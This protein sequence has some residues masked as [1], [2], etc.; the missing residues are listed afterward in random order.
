MKKLAI[1]GTV[2]I[3]ETEFLSILSEKKLNIE[4][5]VVLSC[6]EK[7]IGKEISY[8]FY[9]RLI[10][11]NLHEYNF[12]G[13]DIAVFI[14]NSGTS[15]IYAKKATENGCFVIDSSSYWR[16]NKN[17]PLIIPEINKNKINISKNKNI[18]AVPSASA[19]QLSMILKPLTVLSEISRVVVSTYQAVS[20]S[21]QDA[22][23]ELFE[24]TKKVYENDFMKP[25][26]F[27]KQIPFNLIPQIGNLSKNN[28]YEEENFIINETNKI[29]DTDIKISATC[30]RVP[31]FAC[32]SQSINIEFKDNIEIDNVEE[33]LSDA[34]GI[35][36]LDKPSDY[37]FAT[38]RECAGQDEI[39]ISRIRKDLSVKNGINLWS[40]MDNVRRGK[41]INLINTLE[42]VNDNF[43]N[44]K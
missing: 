36:I 12:N 41:A 17:I 11:K 40:V 15:E 21:G 39:Y 38:P 44:K 28:N 3:V 24:Q 14:T 6:D 33:I 2:D 37:I 18:I 30:I 32:Y 34:E 35:L 26:H 1:I 10:V 22:M 4:E 23:D 19:L 13:T 25:I 5:I 9:Q 31:V 16:E 42:V 27:T 20:G 7:D 8:G 29:L 43:F